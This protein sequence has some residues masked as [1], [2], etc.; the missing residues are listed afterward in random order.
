MGRRARRRSW[1]VLWLP[2]PSSLGVRAVRRSRRS[3]LGR[4]LQPVAKPQQLPRARWRAES[5]GAGSAR[6]AAAPH[7]SRWRSRRLERLRRPSRLRGA[8]S[9]RGSGWGW[10]TGRPSAAGR[11]RST[12]P[13]CDSSRRPVVAV[14]ARGPAARVSGS[15]RPERPARPAYQARARRCPSHAAC[16]PA[17]AASL[18]FAE[19]PGYLLIHE[20]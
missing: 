18:Q 13:R 15:A 17:R 14:V 10:R 11:S 8:R 6:P 9:P 12:R 19:R 2:Q 20:G 7:R 3:D 5:G 4:A 16:A 1:I